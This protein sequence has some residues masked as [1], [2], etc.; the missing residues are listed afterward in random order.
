MS[1]T[2]ESFRLVAGH[3]SSYSLSTQCISVDTGLTYRYLYFQLK[4][5]AFLYDEVATEETEE[6]KQHALIPPVWAIGL[7]HWLLQG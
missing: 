4:S 7:Y 6:A 3:R 5:H 1:L 2:L